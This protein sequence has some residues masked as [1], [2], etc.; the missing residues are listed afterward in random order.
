MLWPK[1][2]WRVR[3]AVRTDVT[4][5]RGG[6]LSRLGALMALGLTLGVLCPSPAG[7]VTGVLESTVLSSWS[8]VNPTISGDLVAW[9]DEMSTDLWTGFGVMRA[10]D[11][12]TGEQ[13]GM[14]PVCGLQGSPSITGGTVYG[15][16]QDGC[17][18][19]YSPDWGPGQAI[20]P[21]V[22]TMS[23]ASGAYAVASFPGG[24]LKVISLATGAVIRTVTDCL[25]VPHERMLPYDLDGRTLAYATPAG[26]AVVLDVPT[27]VSRV[28]G[29]GAHAVA[30]GGGSVA[31]ATAM[32]T[33]CANASAPSPAR[34]MS[35]THGAFDVHADHVVYTDALGALS[36]VHGATMQRINLGSGLTQPKLDA[37]RLVAVL[38]NDPVAYYRFAEEPTISVDGPGSADAGTEFTRWITVQDPDSHLVTVTVAWGDGT[39]ST[40]A[41]MPGSTAIRHTYASAGSYPVLVTP[42]DASGV[43]GVA[44]GFTITV[45][46]VAAAVDDAYT[47]AEDVPLV[48][49]A[50]AG[51]LAN[52]TVPA[53]SAATAVLVTPPAQGSLALHADGSFELTPAA[54]WSGTA[55]FTYKI[56]GPGFVSPPATVRVVV[57]PV[58]D[59]PDI[60]PVSVPLEPL[61]VDTDVLVSAT[62]TD[63]DDVGGHVATWDWGDGTTSEGSID[64][65]SGAAEALAL[66]PQGATLHRVTGSHAYSSPGVYSVSLTIDD[67]SAT[68]KRVA[69]VFVVIYDPDGGFV[70][71]GGW[72][73]SPSGAYT[74]G[75]TGDT[76]V[77]GVAT[78]GFVSKYLKGASVPSGNTEFQFRAAGLDFKATSY[79][80]LVVAGSRGQ[81]KGSGTVNGEGDFGFMLTVIDGQAA[82]DGTADRFRIKIWDR[83]SD[84]VIYDNQPTA[85]DTAGVT[86]ELGGGAVIVHR[87]K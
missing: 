61:V 30:L 25:T 14:G 59:P 39:T 68:P 26:Q 45:R 38:A 44:K 63:S 27:G 71:G 36:Y 3:R 85:S 76:D 54:D 49:A 9:T 57:T 28:V 56:T 55:T 24:P 77:T 82:G 2:M 41:V 58:D 80:W 79:E 42:T 37:R 66:E 53:G 17:L 29:T 4:G 43:L 47:T 72:I 19:G 1:K 83:A 81:F 34:L 60:G 40:Q 13:H 62:F 69:E 15:S 52:D 70:T 75:D 48:V 73:A 11:V 31:W 23:T 35:G 33:F 86:T 84:A 6:R 78:F 5:P 22:G 65:P 20:V 21:G 10:C 67:G 74:P 7:A 32:G 18:V 12:S 87:P 50:P 46:A 51:V 8:A 16:C 64:A